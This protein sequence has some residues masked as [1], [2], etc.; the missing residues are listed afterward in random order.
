MKVIVDEMK[1]ERTHRNLYKREKC[2]IMGTRS[3][4]RGDSWYQIRSTFALAMYNLNPDPGPNSNHNPNPDAL[5]H[6]KPNTD[7]SPNSLA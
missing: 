4:L 7:A 5:S 2:L 3:E 1:L 6:T